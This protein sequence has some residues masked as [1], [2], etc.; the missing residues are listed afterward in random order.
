MSMGAMVWRQQ[1]FI[2][3]MGAA[4]RMRPLSVLLVVVFRGLRGFREHTTTK[5]KKEKGVCV[6]E[7]ASGNMCL[8]GTIFKC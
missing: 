8:D 2:L 6:C 5:N 7:G 4:A 3:F 1:V